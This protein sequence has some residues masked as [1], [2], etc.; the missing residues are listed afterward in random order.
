[1][2]SKI[3]LSYRREAVLD[4]FRHEANRAR[5]R[6]VDVGSF[7]EGGRDP[8]VKALNELAYAADLL[9]AVNDRLDELRGEVEVAGDHDDAI[10]LRDDHV[11]RLEARI[12][13]LEGANATVTPT[14]ERVP[15]VEA[16][17]TSSG[18]TPAR[19]GKAEKAR[20]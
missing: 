15:I 12:S 17:E 11:T 3:G 6:G 14:V 7:P 16:A 5:A 10:A 9:A 20:A 18:R 8:E 19:G 1:M 2:A 4:R 13:E